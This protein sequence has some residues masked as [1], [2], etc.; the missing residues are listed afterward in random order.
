MFC[1]G[2]RST[3]CLFVLDLNQ[4]KQ[5]VLSVKFIFVLCCLL[6]LSYVEVVLGCD[7]S[8]LSCQSFQLNF[9]LFVGI[10]SSISVFYFEAN[11]LFITLLLHSILSLNLGISR[12]MQ[13]KILISGLEIENGCQCRNI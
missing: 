4:A 13:L 12:K 11:H 5:K 8:C 6:V 9:H 10:Y 3:F 1:F 7:K 2:L